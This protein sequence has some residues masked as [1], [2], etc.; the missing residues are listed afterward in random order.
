MD[1]NTNAAGKHFE[2]LAAVLGMATEL[3]QAQGSKVQ[4]LGTCHQGHIMID[5]KFSSRIWTIMAHVDQGR[6]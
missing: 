1:A 4:D 6:R 3:Q 5:E 2:G